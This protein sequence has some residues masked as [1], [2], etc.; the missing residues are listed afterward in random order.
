MRISFW[1]FSIVFFY[2]GLKQSIEDRKKG[3]SKKR[4]RNLFF[5]RFKMCPCRTCSAIFKGKFGSGFGITFFQIFG[6]SICHV[7]SLKKD[8]I[9]LREPDK[10]PTIEKILDEW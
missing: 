4:F 3:L 1:K 6:L 7:R 10:L 5:F 9:I 8:E 2:V